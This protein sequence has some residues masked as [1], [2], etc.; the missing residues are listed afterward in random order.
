[1]HAGVAPRPVPVDIEDDGVGG[2]C[3]DARLVQRDGARPASAA[4][5]LRS[6][7][8]GVASVRK[9]PLSVTCG[10]KRPAAAR[11]QRAPSAGERRPRPPRAPGRA[12]IDRVA[13]VVHGGS[14]ARRGDQPYP[15][16][17]IRGGAEAGSL[18]VA[19]RTALG[20][21]A[22]AF[23]EHLTR[24]RTREAL[25]FGGAMAVALVHAL[26][27]A[28]LHRGP[29]SASGSTLL[30]AASRSSAGSAPSPCFP[31][32]GP[33]SVRRSPSCSARSASSTARC[34]SSTSAAGRARERP[35]RRARRR[36]RTRARRPRRR[37]PVAAPRRGAGT[38]ARAHRVLAVPRRR[39]SRR[40]SS[41]CR[42]ASAITE[43]HKFRE[44]I[45]APPSA[46]LP[47]G[48]VR[49]ERRRRALR[50]VPADP[51][52]RHGPGGPR[53]RRRPPRLGRARVDARPPRL[54][55]AALRRPRARAQRGHAERLGLGLAEGRRGRARV[56]EGA[57]PRSTRSASARSA[58]RPAR[59][60]SSRSPGSGPTS[61][62]SSPTATVA[63]S[64][65]D[66]Q[67]VYG[68]GPMTPFMR[69]VRDRADH[70]GDHAR[71][72]ARGHGGPRDVAAA[73]RR[74]R[75]AGEAAGDVYDRAAGDR[76]VDHW[77]LPTS[78]TP[79]RSARRRP[80][81]SSASRR[82]STGPCAALST[83]RD[84]L[85]RSGGPASGTIARWPRSG[86]RTSGR[87]R[88]PADR[89]APVRPRQRLG[90]RHSRCRRRRTRTSSPTRGTSTPSGTSG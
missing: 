2:E 44:P 82:S 48:G 39:C 35:D 36:G 38:R 1:M 13:D 18:H 87:A 14:L 56:P 16:G 58:S 81:T 6:S 24:K 89:G 3:R 80:R 23:S 57:R 53:R 85:G 34:T 90:R 20:P 75:A 5:T 65:E 77:H 8:S 83:P 62:P 9:N 25:V 67:R 88:A 11:S 40:S 76:P 64:F 73:A 45:G 42:W 79:R 72:A 43:T 59:T 27:D 26:D 61:R 37:D 32:S 22:H 21:S 30:A 66:A 52:R 4:A 49:R 74:G 15:R 63:G 28:F 46:E 31:R 55:R 47:R 60:C 10:M 69:R 12:E 54:R 50:L 84:A 68:V 78:A 51:Q 33:A 71:P 7:S 86:Q 29:A 41:S 70:V 17:R 19:V